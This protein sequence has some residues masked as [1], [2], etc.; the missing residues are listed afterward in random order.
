[1]SAITEKHNAN[2]EVHT[3]VEHMK[4]KMLVND[5]KIRRLK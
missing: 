5:S 4:I 2:P 1:M 3:K